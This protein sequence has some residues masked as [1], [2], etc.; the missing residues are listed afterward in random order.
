MCRADDLAVGDIG[1]DDLDFADLGR[2]EPSLRVFYVVIHALLDV[3][4]FDPA[5]DAHTVERR[6]AINWRLWPWFI[7]SVWGDR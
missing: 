6:L 2:D 3:L 5:Q 7:F 4:R 1:T